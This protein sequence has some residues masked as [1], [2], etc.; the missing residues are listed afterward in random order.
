MTGDK[1]NFLSL[2]KINR[3]GVSFGDGKKGIITGVGKIGSSESK[4]LED[5]YLV[6]GLKHNLL[7]ISQL[8]DKGNK[9]IFTSAGVKVKRMD[10]KEIVLTTR[11]Y[12][13]IYKADIMAIPRLE[14]TCL[15]AIEN[16]PLLWHRRLGH[17]SLKQLNILSSKDMVLGLPKTKFKKEKLC[18]ACARGK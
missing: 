10:T 1:K 14:L 7:S 12:R 2:S 15:S 18:S 4:A 8:C 13:N 17:V 11:R 6:E 5:V 9:V 16:D 3:G